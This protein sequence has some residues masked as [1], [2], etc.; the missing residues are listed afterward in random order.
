MAAAQN[1]IIVKIF[2][3]FLKFYIRVYQGALSSIPVSKMLKS[4]RA[5]TRK[6][7]NS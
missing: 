5:A 3:F 7:I 2:W 4:K 6:V 1:M